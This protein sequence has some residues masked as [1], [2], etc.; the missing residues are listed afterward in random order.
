MSTAVNLIKT[1][2]T[3]AKA[4]QEGTLTTLADC[5]DVLWR[6][7][8][9]GNK[10]YNRLLSTLYK[11][12]RVILESKG[13]EAEAKSEEILVEVFAKTILLG[14]EGKIQGPDGE[15]VGYSLELAKQLLAMKDFRAKVAAASEDFNTFRVAK[16]E[17]DLK[18]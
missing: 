2:G 11:R 6:V 4:E 17:E 13:D 3:D 18:N 14:F 15:M 16:D 5:G 7:A 8:R 1:F 12:N 9:S 10:N